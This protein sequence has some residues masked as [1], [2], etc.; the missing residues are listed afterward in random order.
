MKCTLNMKA[1]FVN[2]TEVVVKIMPE[3]IQACTGREPMTSA[4]PVRCTTK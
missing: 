1:T 4:I 2:I 3:K